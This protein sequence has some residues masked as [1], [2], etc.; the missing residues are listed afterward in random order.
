MSA[1]KAVT[2]IFQSRLV[3][4]AGTTAL[5]ADGDEDEADE[6]IAG[7]ELEAGAAGDAAG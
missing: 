1:T 2:R 5:G 6:I 3:P 4:A 7:A